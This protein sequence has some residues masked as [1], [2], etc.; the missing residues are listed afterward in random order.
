[1]KTEDLLA[2]FKARDPR[3]IG[4]V[5]SQVENNGPQCSAILAA[6]GADVMDS[7]LVLGLTGP[8]GAGKSTLSGCLIRHLREQGQRVGI[9]AIDPSSPISGGAVLGDRIRIMDHAL[10]PDV[11]V[12]S[13]ASRGRL[14]G[15]CAAAGGV[16]R[17]L[18]AAGCDVIL[19]ETV[20]VGQ[21]EMDIV[22]LAD[23]TLMT[24]APGFGDD[25]QAMK[26]GLLEVTD[27]LVAN[28]ADLPGS[29]ALC[30][31][32]SAT[33]RDRSQRDGIDR[34]VRTV[35]SQNQGIDTL[36]DRIEALNTNHL[37][38]GIRTARRQLSLESETLDWCLELL[39]PQ[40]LAAIRGQHQPIDP[41]LRAEQ[42]I[43]DRN[44]DQR[45]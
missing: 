36:M 2:R 11:I 33:F 37:E 31:E 21:S 42:L 1:M 10:D 35:A 41:R 32:M 39:R 38:Q 40:L 7:T 6:L 9:I 23:L 20:G 12:R 22:R 19:I 18:A 13:M 44:H 29:E 14:G 24:L 28:K 8:P 17:V 34:V 16:V 30:L 43:A 26:A 15:L 25:I 3:A 5:I 4:Q 27:L 45:Q